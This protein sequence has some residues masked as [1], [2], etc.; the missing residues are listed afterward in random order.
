MKA[1]NTSEPGELSESIR[2][3]VNIPGEKSENHGPIDLDE[4]S[5][6]TEVSEKTDK[7]NKKKASWFGG[8]SRKQKSGV[9]SSDMGIA[10]DLVVAKEP[11]RKCEGENEVRAHDS[12]DPV[13]HT[14]PESPEPELGFGLNSAE[15]KK[16]DPNDSDTMVPENKN[17]E[18]TLSTVEVMDRNGIQIDCGGTIGLMYDS[19]GCKDL[20]E[21]GEYLL[22]KESIVMAKKT[23]G[24]V[25]VLAGA[26]KSR[27]QHQHVS[28]LE[29]LQ[30]PKLFDG[31]DEQCGEFKIHFDYVGTEAMEAFQN[32][33]AMAAELVREK[34]VEIAREHALGDERAVDPNESIECVPADLWEEYP[35]DEGGPT[36]ASYGKITAI[37]VRELMSM[38]EV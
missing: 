33:K 1:N 12:S 11:E 18:T 30:S 21:T 17:T 32:F 13:G 31:M 14:E 22:D 35:H 36:G 4:I 38:Q 9:Y 29:H 25:A 24:G 10:A 7:R 34:E 8:K 5:A 27:I 26:E 37:S 28:V 23:L 6:S 2:A 20:G 3:F 16:E 19:C 15:E